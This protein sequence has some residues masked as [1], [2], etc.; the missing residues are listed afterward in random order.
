MS[1][2]RSDQPDGTAFGRYTLFER[3][4]ET[5]LVRSYRARV[6][7]LEGFERRLSLIH[8]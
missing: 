6:G 8:I 1:E 5:E 3:L 2:P 4:G 7:G